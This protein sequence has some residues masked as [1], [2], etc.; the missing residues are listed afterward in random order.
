MRD[1]VKWTQKAGIEVSASFM[2]G[3]PGETPELAR[4]TI[5]FAISLDL[6]YAIFSLTTPYPGTTLYEEFIKQGRAESKLDWGKYTCHMPIYLPEGYENRK[7]LVQLH[8]EAYRRFY[9]R[10]K[11][12]MRKLSKINSREDI[13]RYIRGIKFLLKMKLLHNSGL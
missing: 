1:A 2:L 9:L 12:F 11:Y 5:D 13:R 6:D 4:K 3:L 8:K 10:P 7:Q